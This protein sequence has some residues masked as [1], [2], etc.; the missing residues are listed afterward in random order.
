MLV[1]LTPDA[2]QLLSLLIL[3]HALFA[4]STLLKSQYSE[5]TMN[6]TSVTQLKSRIR[7]VF[8]VSRDLKLCVRNLQFVEVI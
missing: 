1:R 2:V 4:V 7:T 3:A 8:Q 6:L 5:S